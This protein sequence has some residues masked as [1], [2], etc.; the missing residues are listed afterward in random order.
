MASSSSNEMEFRDE[1]LELAAANSLASEKKKTRGRGARS[2][3]EIPVEVYGQS[4]A[5]VKVDISGQPKAVEIVAV[6]MDASTSHESDEKAASSGVSSSSGNGNAASM[7]ASSIPDRQTASSCETS[8]CPTT[9]YLSQ[10]D[11]TNRIRAQVFFD[12]CKQFWL[13]Y[14]PLQ[15]I[16]FMIRQRQAQKMFVENSL[17]HNLLIEDISTPEE[18]IR[19]SVIRNEGMNHFAIVTRDDLTTGHVIADVDPRHWYKVVDGDPNNIKESLVGVLAATTINVG[20]DDWEFMS[21]LTNHSLCPELMTDA[22]GPWVPI[23]VDVS[24]MPTWLVFKSDP[25]TSSEFNSFMKIQNP[26][27]SP[28]INDNSQTKLVFPT[29]YEMS[30]G[31]SLAKKNL[32]IAKQEA[33]HARELLSPVSTSILGYGPS[34]T[35]GSAY[36]PMIFSPSTLPSVPPSF[37]VSADNA[38]LS[39]E[40]VYT[41]SLSNQQRN[42]YADNLR[43]YPLLFHILD[44]WPF[45]QRIAWLTARFGSPHSLVY[46]REQFVQRWTQVSHLC[47]SNE[48]NVRCMTEKLS[49]TLTLRPRSPNEEIID[50]D[51]EINFFDAIVTKTNQPASKFKLPKQNDHLVQ[52]HMVKAAIMSWVKCFSLFFEIDISASVRPFIE[53]CENPTHN[54]MEKERFFFIKKLF[55]NLC[56]AAMLT[57]S[58]VSN[59]F[60][61]RILTSLLTTLKERSESSITLEREMSLF[62]A[63]GSESLVQDYRKRTQEDEPEDSDPQGGSKTP[64]KQKGTNQQKASVVP[65]VTVLATCFYDLE[66]KAKI[67][68]GRGCSSN[69]CNLG[70]HQPD[71]AAYLKVA[72]SKSKLI[73]SIANVRNKKRLKAVVDVIKAHP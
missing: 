59:S 8:A 54:L 25:N 72:G 12:K 7:D 57:N 62:A 71:V 46:T 22:A 55:Y 20:A 70:V 14:Y 9:S 37:T 31:F 36:C 27:L 53:F 16:P 44:C 50:V 69:P 26:Y 3:L 56:N 51:S 10:T 48:I 6:S 34:T 2:S 4:K 65:S 38:N 64:K 63:R 66:V 11:V 40:E 39:S 68:G 30:K 43:K 23:D 35:S 1:D 32:L 47:C 21:I 17:R 49:A 60:G 73:A 19:L 45:P 15:E 18:E 52:P 61:E 58:S 33:A 24:D 29:F 5:P 67:S 41:L 28:Y 42:Y 13:Q